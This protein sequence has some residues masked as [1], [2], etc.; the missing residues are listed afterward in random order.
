MG[1]TTLYAHRPEY[2]IG[3]FPCNI[4]LHPQGGF[5]DMAQVRLG[6]FIPH[7]VQW[8]RLHCTLIGK[9]MPSAFFPCNEIYIIVSTVLYTWFKLGQESLYA[10]CTMSQATL[11]TYRPEYNICFFCLKPKEYPLKFEHFDDTGRKFAELYAKM[12]DP[13]QHNNKNTLFN[14]L[15]LV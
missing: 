10:V 3:F 12:S 14:N 7:Y 6:M 8:A 5:I 2:A 9:S 15:I 1:Q 4:L 11:Y 13:F